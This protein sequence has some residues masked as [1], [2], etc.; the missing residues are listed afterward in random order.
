VNKAGIATSDTGFVYGN[1]WWV[2]AS[3]VKKLMC[4]IR[5][6]EYKDRWYYENWLSFKIKEPIKT[7][8]NDC[9]INNNHTN[10][11]DSMNKN[12]DM[13]CPCIEKYS[14]S[15]PKDSVTLCPPNTP[16]GMSFKQEAANG[17]EKYIPCWNKEVMLNGTVHYQQHEVIYTLTNTIVAQKD[18]Y[19]NFK[20]YIVYF[21]FI[22]PKR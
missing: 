4:P 10:I 14:Y 2:R 16:I 21:A 19:F 5:Y 13:T 18:P 22:P 6:K 17:I 12:E 1:F 3:Y 20:L 11:I 7:P 9:M 8:E 15:G